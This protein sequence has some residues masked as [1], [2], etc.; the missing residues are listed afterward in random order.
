MKEKIERIL[1]TNGIVVLD[2]NV[3]L[4]IYDRSPEFSGFSIEVLNSIKDTVYLPQIVKN[5]FLKNHR[6]CFNRQKKKVEK[7][8]EKLL[9]ITVQ[10]SLRSIITI[11]KPD[12]IS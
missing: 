4:N 7:A 2:T 1:N 5:E 3:Y 12:R 9:T 11:L 10:P 8:C 6:E